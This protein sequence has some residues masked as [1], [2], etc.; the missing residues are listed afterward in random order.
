M[1]QGEKLAKRREKVNAISHE[2]IEKITPIFNHIN[3]NPVYFYAAMAQAL[4]SVGTC[5]G[6]TDKTQKMFIDDI[7]ILEKPEE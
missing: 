7:L 1:P 3:E 5:I 4:V 2:I 6:M